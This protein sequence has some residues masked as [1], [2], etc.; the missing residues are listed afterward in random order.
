M[1]PEVPKLNYTTKGNFFLIAGPCVVENEKMPMEIAEKILEIT[2]SLEI[3][4]IFKASYRKANRSR[5]DSFAGIGDKK[6]LEAIRN[7]GEHFNIPTLTD[8]H[9]EEEA[10]RAALYVDVLQIPAFL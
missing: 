3:P 7:V 10:I 5:V 2:E 4:F 1:L 8:I 9:T 6:A